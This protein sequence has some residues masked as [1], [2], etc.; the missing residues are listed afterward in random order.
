MKR[1]TSGTLICIRFSSKAQIYVR[2]SWQSRDLWTCPRGSIGWLVGP[3]ADA[4][5]LRGSF[6]LVTRVS[7]DSSNR[8]VEGADVMIPYENSAKIRLYMSNGVD[9]LPAGLT[10]FCLVADLTSS[11][12]MKSHWNRNRARRIRVRIRPHPVAIEGRRTDFTGGLYPANS[13]F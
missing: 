2:G 3:I 13:S 10:S 1:S 8:E 6:E 12:F 4:E 11:H 7:D 5:S 9:A